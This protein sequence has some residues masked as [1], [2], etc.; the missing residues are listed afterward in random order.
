VVLWSA[1]QAEFESVC[2]GL[3]NVVVAADGVTLVGLLFESEFAP[4]VVRN[5]RFGKPD[6]GPVEF[7]VPWREGTST[8]TAR[9]QELLRILAPLG[10]QPHVEVLRFDLEAQN[11]ET[12]AVTFRFDAALYLASLT[13]RAVLIPRHRCHVHLVTDRHPDGFQ[14][15]VKSLQPYYGGDQGRHS[16]EGVQGDDLRIPSYSGGRVRLVAGSASQKGPVRMRDRTRPKL[17]LRAVESQEVRIAGEGVANRQPA[18]NRIG[19]TMT[20]THDVDTRG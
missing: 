2:P 11:P 5:P 17:Q 13:E 1:V 18:A 10:R 4:Y 3:R 9:R 16:P 12:E 14:M 15:E 8:R 6:G 19:F 20:T 7:E